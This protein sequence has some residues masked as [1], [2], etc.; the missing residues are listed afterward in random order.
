LSGASSCPLAR[1]TGRRSGGRPTAVVRALRLTLAYDGGGYHGWQVQPNARTVQG[2]LVEAAQQVTGGAVRVTGASRTDAGVHALGQVVSLATEAAIS[3][4]SL[5]AAL[6]ARLPPDIRV[7][8]AQEVAPPFDARRAAHGKRYAYVID[9]GEVA[10]PFTRRYAWHVRG[11]LDLTA[12]RAGLARLRGRHD[13]SAFCAAPGRDREPTRTLRSI[14]V[15]R[16]RRLVGIFLS[17]DG[18]LHHM[19]R[20]IVGSAVEVGHGRQDPAWLGRLLAGRDRTLAG[21][22][23][24]AHGL[25]LLRVLYARAESLRPPGRA[26]GRVGDGGRAR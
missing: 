19:A 18:F 20:N 24:P 12:M 17:G 6:N 5:R 16:A 15:V 26:A 14:R 8:D 10:L 9:N 1:R 25:I 13:F 3:A 22:T 11:A 4:P 21:P 7:L 2:C 23:A